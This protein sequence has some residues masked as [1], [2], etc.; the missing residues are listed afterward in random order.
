[1]KLWPILIAGIL[2][3]G[4]NRGGGAKNPDMTTPPERNPAGGAPSSVE[5]KLFGSWQGEMKDKD[6]NQKKK[7][8]DPTKKT[9]DHTPEMSNSLL[10][11][12]GG[13]SLDLR[14][15]YT[16]TL[17]M[18]GLTLDGDWELVGEDIKLKPAKILDKTKDE[19]KADESLLAGD[20]ISMFDKP[21]VPK[22]R[23][24]GDQLRMMSDPAGV[25]TF[26]KK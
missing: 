19:W 16:F 13:Y 20:M 7:P 15:D 14:N 17:S 6:P 25:I 26:K 12:M 1:M 3:A 9:E 10:E 4:C 5:V 21:P 2:I 11:V 18:V 23:E 24:G 8:G 22:V